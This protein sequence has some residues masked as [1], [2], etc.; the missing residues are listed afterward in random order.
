MVAIN[1]INFTYPIL[2]KYNDDYIDVLFNGGSTG[3]LCQ[4]GKKATIKTYVELTDD[5]LRELIKQNRANII[6]KIYCRSTKY[7][8]IFYIKSGMDEITLNNRDI[9]K[10]VDMQT[11]IIATDNIKNYYSVNFNDDYKGMTF[12]IEKGSVLAIGKTENIYIEKDVDELTNVNSIVRIKDS[13]KNSG[14][15]FVEYDEDFIKINLNSKEYQIY[16]RYSKYDLSIIN[17]MVVIPGLMF[18]LDQ[19]GMD[20]SDDYLTKKWYRVIS[21]RI[22]RAI[23]KEFNIEY[24]KAYGSFEIIQKILDYPIIDAMNEISKRHGGDC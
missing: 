11:L 3:E 22:S 13:G 2:Y 12:S 23:G 18:V 19:L 17:S 10:N 1:D 8:K 21:K 6:V 20:E 16:S 15:M 5:N 9:N 14:P 24:I 4:T 7:R